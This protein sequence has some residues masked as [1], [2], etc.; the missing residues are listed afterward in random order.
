VPVIIGSRRDF[1]EWMNPRY[2]RATAVANRLISG[3]VTN[4]EAVKRLTV[5]VEGFPS[6]RIGVV[7]NGIRLEDFERKPP[8]LELRES[9]SIPNGARVVGLI[10]NMRPMKRQETFLRCARR[11]L[12][13]R[14]DLIFL[15]V[16]ADR[17][18]HGPVLRRL[19]DLIGELG[20]GHAVRIAQ[21]EGNV[22]EF[23]SIM[24]VGV[25]FSQGEGLSNALMEC[26]AFGIPCVASDSGG[27][28]DLV[29]HMETGLLFPLDDVEGAA[30]AIEQVLIDGVFAQQL[31]A[32]AKQRLLEEMTVPAA[33]TGLLRCYEMLS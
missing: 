9:L 24:D 5:Q 7:H 14:P 15:L 29:R 26:M 30:A 21:A 27:N 18:P 17:A 28:P 3:I 33:A 2:L 12:Q 16:G 23:L 8:N 22:A 11:M 20:I 6:S 31:A 32:R 13:S 4:S 25:S 1:G 10:G 19:Q